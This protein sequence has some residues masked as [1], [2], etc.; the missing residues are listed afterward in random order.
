MGMKTCFSAISLLNLLDDSNSVNDL[1]LDIV[2]WLYDWQSIYYGHFDILNEPSESP[3]IQTCSE[4]A[5]IRSLILNEVT[6][7]LVLC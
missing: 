5:T 6:L 3:L 7:K 2:I 4:W 1:Q